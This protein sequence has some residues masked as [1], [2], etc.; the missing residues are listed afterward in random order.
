MKINKFRLNLDLSQTV[1]GTGSIGRTLN[2]VIPNVY[3]PDGATLAA[4]ATDPGPNYP[5]FVGVNR[6][7]VIGGYPQRYNITVTGTI[8][9]SSPY[10]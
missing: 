1:V 10:S 6:V 7:D 3:L 9:V 5:K 2:L 8:T 4:V